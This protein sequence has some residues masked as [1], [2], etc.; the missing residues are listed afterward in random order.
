MDTILRT[1]RLTLL[2]P[3]PENLEDMLR[4]LSDRRSTPAGSPLALSWREEAEGLFQR[5][6]RH[7]QQHEAGCY[8][9]RLRGKDRT[10]GFAGVTRILWDGRP[11][12]QLHCLLEHRMRGQGYGREAAAAV[13]AQANEYFELPPILAR[14]R[15]QDQAA[16]RLVLRLGFAL[17]PHQGADDAGGY[18]DG[19]VL[20]WDRQL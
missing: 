3:G 18:A 17:D 16:V 20:N 5:W 14:V 7:W 1:K 11:V 2:R 15:P 4:I 9:V 13:V 12:L 10:V 8:T 19:Y 6:D